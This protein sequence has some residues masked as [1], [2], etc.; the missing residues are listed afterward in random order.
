MC[1]CTRVLRVCFFKHQLRV[2]SVSHTRRPNRLSK[3]TSQTQRSLENWGS[4][5]E[6]PSAPLPEADWAELMFEWNLMKLADR[7]SVV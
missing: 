7:K 5:A 1:A 6:G 4:D 2:S 3:K